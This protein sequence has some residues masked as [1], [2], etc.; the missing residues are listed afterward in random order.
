MLKYAKLNVAILLGAVLVLAGCSAHE[1]KQPQ[2]PDEFNSPI[3]RN[4]I[5]SLFQTQKAA[6]ARADST[7]YP[8]HFDGP[9]LSSLGTTKLDLI[10]LDS[11]STNPL[12]IYIAV[13]NDPYAAQHRTVISNYLSDRGGLKTEQI[14]FQDGPNPAT[15][16]PA[17]DDIKN[18]AN[19][20]ATA[21]GAAST[22]G[23]G[24]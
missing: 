19:T 18:L 6:G 10:L 15:Y 23:G 12:T 13:E 20:D 24:K 4:Q 8:Q 7:L 22:G 2:T 16:G 21:S 5:G 17:E 1:Q 14:A 11:H 3:E 9:N